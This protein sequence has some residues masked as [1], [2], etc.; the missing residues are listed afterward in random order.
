MYNALIE[1]KPK[2]CFEI[3]TFT[4][5]GST[6]F[7]ASAFYKNSTG[8]L[9]TIESDDRLYNKAKNF[10]ANKLKS[11]NK[12]TEFIKGDNFSFI[13]KHI[14]DGKVDCFFL[15][16]A[17]DGNQTLEQYNDFLPY[18]KT[19]TIMMLHDWNT[20]KTIKV[21]NLILQDSG[22]KMISELEPPISVGF[23]IF[24]RA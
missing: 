15:D 9:I 13:E 18:C 14:T 8:K 11:L 6:F 5:G 22:W 1:Y 3:G 12:H 24:V 19:G 23:V 16:G 2:D 17:E 10:Y 20:E 7:I 21:K 4:G